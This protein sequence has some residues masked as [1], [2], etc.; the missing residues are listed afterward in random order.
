MITRLESPT[1]SYSGNNVVSVGATL[2]VYAE[3]GAPAMLEY[4]VTA[5]YDITAED[6][7]A[8]ISRQLVT[9][10]G[11]YLA[12]LAEVDAYRAHH[13]P[14]AGDFE[15]AANQLLALANTQLTG[16]N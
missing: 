4:L 15:A 11:A 3:D 7:P 14:D 16:G 8:E 12:K 10:A 1:Y 2:R 5:S 9:E 6:F 13:F